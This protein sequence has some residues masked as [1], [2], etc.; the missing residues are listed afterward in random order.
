MRAE[1]DN[2]EFYG[3]Y[4]GI[5]CHRCS[6]QTLHQCLDIRDRRTWLRIVLGNWW[7]YGW[8]VEIDMVGILPLGYGLSWHKPNTLTLV[9]HPIPLNAVMRMAREFGCWLMMGGPLQYG[10]VQDRIDAEVARR[11]QFHEH[12]VRR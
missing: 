9:M 5:T 2:R 12:K 4:R 8:R 10:T 7:Q 1:V 6:H 3:P 11:M